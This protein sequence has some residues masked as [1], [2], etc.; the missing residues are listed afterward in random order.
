MADYFHTKECSNSNVCLMSLNLHVQC[1]LTSF[2][3]SFAVGQLQV[4]RRGQQMY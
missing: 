4:E 1:A 2:S 3:L